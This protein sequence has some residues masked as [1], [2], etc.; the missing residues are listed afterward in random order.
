MVP[1]AIYKGLTLLLFVWENE[2]TQQ[3]EKL[4][5]SETKRFYYSVFQAAPAK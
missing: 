5:Q 3:K 4:C 1:F 2:L